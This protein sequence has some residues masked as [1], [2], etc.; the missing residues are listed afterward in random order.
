MLCFLGALLPLG[1]SCFLCPSERHVIYLQGIGYFVAGLLGTGLLFYAAS[2]DK[3]DTVEE[4]TLRSTWTDHLDSFSPDSPVKSN[5]MPALSAPE[6]VQHVLLFLSFL[7]LLLLVVL[8][9]LLLS[10]P[11][12]VLP[13]QLEFST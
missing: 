13:E 9:R 2:R 7:L 6:Q 1:P 11:P 3:S 12:L 4:G 8:L 5:S 10:F